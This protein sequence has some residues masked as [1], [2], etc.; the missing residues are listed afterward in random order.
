MPAQQDEGCAHS[1]GRPAA[2]L[3]QVGIAVAPQSDE[4]DMY[5]FAAA[6]KKYCP[7]HHL[8]I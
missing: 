7:G 2:L 5:S 6:T 1:R 4:A 8:H 3:P